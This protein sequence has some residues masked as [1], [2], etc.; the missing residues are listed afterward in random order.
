MLTTHQILLEV[1]R[2]MPKI[3][4]KETSTPKSASMARK[5]HLK[6]KLKKVNTKVISKY[7][8]SPQKI[9]NEL[10]MGQK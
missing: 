6:L 7:L 8:S 1:V 9:K 5:C 2:R 4:S 10:P 3:D